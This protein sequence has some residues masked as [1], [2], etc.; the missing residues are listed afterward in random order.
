M[1]E[2][3]LE[4]LAA[5]ELTAAEL[6]NLLE[7]I[8]KTELGSDAPTVGAVAE[9]TGLTAAEVG[10]LLAD[11][12]GVSFQERFGN[13]LNDHEG[14]IRLIEKKLGGISPSKVKDYSHDA[15]N[16]KLK[17]DS[18]PVRIDDV[19]VAIF[20]ALLVIL[21]WWAAGRWGASL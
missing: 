6:R 8:G 15:Q 3:T 19:V 10:H 9:A 12:R 20:C 1:T 11:L 21:I 2:S 5:Q 17:P 7:R 13:V 14:R 18:R 4:E 16:F